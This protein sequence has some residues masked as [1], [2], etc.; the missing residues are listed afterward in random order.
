MA[1]N[2][3]CTS[4]G[5]LLMTRSTAA[6][7][8]CATLAAV[9]SA[10]RASA[11]RR[12]L[13][14]SRK[15]ASANAAC[16]ARVSS[17]SCSR[18]SKRPRHPSISAY[19]KSRTSPPAPMGDTRHERCC[20]AATPC[21][22]W[23][24]RLAPLLRASRN[25][26]NTACT[27]DSTSSVRGTRAEMTVGLACSSETSSTRCAPTHATVSWTSRLNSAASLARWCRRRMASGKA[28]VPVCRFALAV[29]AYPRLV[30]R[31]TLVPGLGASHAT[32]CPLL[33]RVGVGDGLQPG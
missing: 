11:V 14:T 28:E 10:A 21:G 2:T 16:V 22:P 1:S 13:S 30:H 31:T 8:A 15:C 18:S 23:R 33:V 27:S 26:G 6:V 4:V 25:Q 5:E 29:I 19:S 32:P 12:S 24:R 17:F 7:A 3:G 9:D 20:V